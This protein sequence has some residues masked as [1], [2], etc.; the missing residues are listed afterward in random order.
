VRSVALSPD[1]RRLAAGAA[2]GWIVVW[3]LST[4]QVVWKGQASTAAVLSL[5]FSADGALLLSGSS[6]QRVRLWDA[7]TGE[8]RAT[9]TG[10]G[11]A[12]AISP[13]RRLVVTGGE[14]VP[15]RIWDAASGK[16]ILTF[17]RFGATALA[18]APCGRAVVCGYGG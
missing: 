17:L 1:G 3:D 15:L 16:P 12:D 8:K 5:G 6:D 4:A 7:A 2:D 9:L 18:F 10:A 14:R 13:D 11:P